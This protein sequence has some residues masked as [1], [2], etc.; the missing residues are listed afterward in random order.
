MTV[1]AFRENHRGVGVSEIVG[2][3][4]ALFKAV[5]TFVRDNEIGRHRVESN[6]ERLVGGSSLYLVNET[7]LRDIVVF[8]IFVFFVVIISI[9]TKR[10]LVPLQEL[11]AGDKILE[12][13]RAFDSKVV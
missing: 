2:A 12:L 6:V 10:I 9:V 4:L 7:I 11:V 5:F 8:V 13:A 1:L 3:R